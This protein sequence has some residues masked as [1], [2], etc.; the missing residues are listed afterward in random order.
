MDKIISEEKVIIYGLFECDKSEEIRYI[1]KTTKSIRTR[2]SEHKYSSKRKKS[3]KD[4]WMQSVYNKNK[5][6][7][8]KI[9]EIVNENNWEERERFWIKFYKNKGCKLTNLQIGGQLGP[10]GGGKIK[11][12]ITYEECKKWINK[13][14]PKLMSIKDFKKIKKELPNH[15]PKDIPG[16][17]KNKG[18]NGWED[19]LNKKQKG[20]VL[21]SHTREILSYSDAKKFLK[22]NQ[23]NLSTLE[24][25][26]RYTRN[27]KL[28]FLPSKPQKVYKSRNDKWISLEDFLPNYNT[29]FSKK[30]FLNY[31][32]A[33]KWLKENRPDII[34][35][36]QYHKEKENN[37]LP[38][39]LPYHAERIYKN[40]W[41]GYT[42]FFG[43]KK[44]FLNFK[45]AKKFVKKNGIKTNRQYRDFWKKY[46]EV[47]P[48]NPDIKYTEWIDWYDFFSK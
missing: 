6:I 18:W 13:N 10:R 14:Y 43:N 33:K 31:N 28:Y 12:F 26:K 16:V 42:D 20:G 32:E 23:P 2:L 7:D 15:I 40:E 29:K 5:K 21:N 35:C 25:Y 9:I 22:K 41:K 3:Y 30:E 1:G 11:Y 38:Y 39:F 8:I 47:I 46:K 24:E 27:K 37:T 36:T 17:F 4:K 45:E 44:S 19:F 34:Y 48:S